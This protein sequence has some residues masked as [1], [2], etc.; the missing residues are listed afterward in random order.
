MLEAT[1]CG[2]DDANVRVLSLE[3]V[4]TDLDMKREVHAPALEA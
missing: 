3:V 1:A 2:L 4:R